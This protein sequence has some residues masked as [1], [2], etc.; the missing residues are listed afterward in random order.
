MCVCNCKCCILEQTYAAMWS[1]FLFVGRCN[2]SFVL[3]GTTNFQCSKLGIWL[4]ISIGCDGLGN[5]SC[6]RTRS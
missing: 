4:I 5:I 6:G 2:V 3:V 1:F